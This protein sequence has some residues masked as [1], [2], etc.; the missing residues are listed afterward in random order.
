MLNS[1]LGQIKVNKVFIFLNILCGEYVMGSVFSGSFIHACFILRQ[2]F[3]SFI[4]YFMIA[5]F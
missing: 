5:V 2:V 1:N 4:Y 3:S